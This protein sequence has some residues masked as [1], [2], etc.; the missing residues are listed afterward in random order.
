[1]YLTLHSLSGLL[2]VKFIAIGRVKYIITIIVNI[3]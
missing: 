3:W 1:M 2:D